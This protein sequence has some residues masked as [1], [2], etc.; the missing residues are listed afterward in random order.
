VLRV[1]CRLGFLVVFVLCP[2]AWADVRLTI[3]VRE[4]NTP[5]TAAIGSDGGTSTD[6][7]VGQG[8]EWVGAA[9]TSSG[10][11]PQGVLVPADDQWH[12]VAFDMT[13]GPVIPF[14]STA[15]GHFNTRNGKSP[16]EHLAIASTGQAGPYV[17]YVDNV[18]NIYTNRG[19]FDLELTGFEGFGVGTE[20]LFQEPGFLVPGPEPTTEANVVGAGSALVTDELASVGTQSTKVEWAFTDSSIDRWIRLSTWT[21]DANDPDFIPFGSPVL[22]LPPSGTG[23]SRVEMDVRLVLVPEPASVGLLALSAGW[24]LK[25]RRSMARSRTGMT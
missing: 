19:V 24:V 25:R 15:S 16:L 5:G 18:R 14:S 10:G 4:T 12:T 7:E 1:N 11:A 23:P 21:R 17:L 22:Q 6:H 3:G 9:T 2:T 8:I 20:A 13:G